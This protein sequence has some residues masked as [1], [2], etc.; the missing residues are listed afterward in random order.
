MNSAWKMYFSTN[1]DVTDKRM[2]LMLSYGTFTNSFTRIV[3]AIAVTQFEFK[4]IY[5][6]LALSSILVCLSMQRFTM[7][8]LFAAG[9]SV[10]VYV[11]IG[12]QTAIFP[13]LCTKV[14]GAVI[15]PQVFP[16]VFAFVM[17]ANAS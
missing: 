6:A 7:N 8:Y 9:Y 14:F 10:V 11:G 5:L 16:I 17:L 15:G 1:L 2:S 4:F 13:S 12:I 3:A